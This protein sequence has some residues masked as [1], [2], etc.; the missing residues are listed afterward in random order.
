MYLH[1]NTGRT[2]GVSSASTPLACHTLITITLP[3]LSRP[4]PVR[5]PSGLTS[6]IL[7]GSLH[8]GI[9]V[10]ELP[11]RRAL[12]ARSCLGPW[13]CFLLSPCSLNP[14][15]TS[16]FCVPWTHE[17]ASGLKV[18]GHAVSSFWET[19]PSPFAWLIPVLLILV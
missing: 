18:P 9:K 1:V 17:V 5:H 8:L 7:L 2:V 4:Q 13:S 6:T 11:S 15:P 12:H 16:L 14:S 3:N 19:L 10:S